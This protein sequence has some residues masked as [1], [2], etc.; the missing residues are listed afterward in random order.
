MSIETIK[1]QV[2]NYSVTTRIL[3]DF[4]ERGRPGDMVSDLVLSAKCGRDT[5]PGS[6]GYG[7]LL[8]AIKHCERQGVVWRRDRGL[9]RIVCLTGLECVTYAKETRLHVR[10]ASKRALARLGGVERRAPM[11]SRI[12]EHCLWRSRYTCLK[13]KEKIMLEQPACG[14]FRLNVLDRRSHEA[15]DRSGS[16]S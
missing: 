7:N 9:C 4:L 8:T 10:R 15:E 5:R 1:P 12:C 13:T 2:S 11:T 16:R 14:Q 3:I 6:D